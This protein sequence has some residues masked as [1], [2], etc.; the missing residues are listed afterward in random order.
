M[1]IPSHPKV[2]A[3]N[4]AEGYVPFTQA[5]LRP[6]TPTDLRTL[7]LNPELVMRELRGQSIPLDEVKA[8]QRRN[9][10]LQRA[11]T[12]LILIRSHAKRRRIPL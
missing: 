11:T 3:K 9:Q 6:L 7:C 8:L 10:L 4:I 5:T 12:A 1:P 2:F